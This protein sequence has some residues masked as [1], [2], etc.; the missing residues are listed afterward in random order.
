MMGAKKL[1]HIGKIKSAHGLKGEVF[2]LVFSKDMSWL[3]KVKD[4]YLSS[5]VS[6]MDEKKTGKK[7]AH[8]EN[9]KTTGKIQCAIKS[10]KPYKDGA[11]ICLNE[12]T[13]RNQS[14]AILGQQV[15]VEE[16]AFVSQDNE[17]LYLAEIENFLV[18][19]SQ[20]GEIGPIKGFS[21][22]HGQDLL[23]VESQLDRKSI[24]E[25]PFVDAYVTRIDMENKILFMELPKGLLDI[26]KEDSE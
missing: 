22:N 21:T 20:L 3:N 16:S 15:W 6:D 12:V 26:N 4:I 19:D 25:I 24:F 7:T 8:G 1:R 17:T 13:N 23:L 2:L 14:E 9:Q 5:D 11:L 18:R 10:F